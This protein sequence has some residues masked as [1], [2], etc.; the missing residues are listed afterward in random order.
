MLGHS[1]S[2]ARSAYIRFS[3]AFSASS[4]RG[5]AA[6]GTPPS[7]SYVTATICDS[8]NLAFFIVSPVKFG[9]VQD[10]PV[11]R[12]GKATRAI[13]PSHWIHEDGNIAARRFPRYAQPWL[14]AMLE[15]GFEEMRPSEE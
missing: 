7:P 8:V 4:L 12:T 9:R 10:F 6:S 2:S 5:S 13:A 3:S 14:F 1:S 15:F 11:P